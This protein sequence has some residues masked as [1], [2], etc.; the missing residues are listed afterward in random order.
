VFFLKPDTALLRNN[1]PFY[2]PEFSNEIHH[3]IELVVR[4]NRIGKHIEPEFAHRYYSDV[5][6][7]VDFTARDVQRQCKEK[8]LPWEK[9]KSF[10][11]SAPLASKFI[12][13]KKLPD[14]AAINF[15]LQI[16]GET[17]QKGNTADMIFSI[18]QLIA[19]LSKYITLKIGDLIYT[20]TPAGVG[21]V[22]IGDRLAG[23]IEDQELLNFEIR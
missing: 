6:L 17:V 20:G 3:E 16:N 8:G 22:K 15:M 18:D 10:D 5:S 7:G 9:A 1:Q 13:L 2:L 12:N 21:P 11:H 23:Y 4:I 19:H 14:A